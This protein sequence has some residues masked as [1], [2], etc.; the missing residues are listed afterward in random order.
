[1]FAAGRLRGSWFG[2]RSYDTL[3]SGS[4]DQVVVVNDEA[5]GR[6]RAI[7]IGKELGPLAALDASV[8]A[9]ISSGTRGLH[10]V[11]GTAGGPRGR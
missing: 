2:Y 10:P 11:V 7:A 6:V 8:V 4:G 5:S 3:P 1:M 9:V